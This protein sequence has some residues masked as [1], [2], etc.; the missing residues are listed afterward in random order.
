MEATSK[1]DQFIGRE[2][3]GLSP[4]LLLL[5]ES[6]YVCY[7][8]RFCCWR[9]IYV[10]YFV[11]STAAVRQVSPIQEEERVKASAMRASRVKRTTVLRLFSRVEEGGDGTALPERSSLLRRRRGTPIVVEFEFW[12]GLKLDRGLRHWT[13][14]SR[15]AGGFLVCDDCARLL[16]YGTLCPE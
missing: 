1:S 7:C 16:L 5:A 8:M 10:S 3:G 9:A 4:T 2:G 15:P 13:H 6:D 14:V 11:H 12:R